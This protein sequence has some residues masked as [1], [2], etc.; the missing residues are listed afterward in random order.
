MIKVDI[1]KR[2]NA[3][4]QRFAK[5]DDV[6]VSVMIYYNYVSNDWIVNER[7]S[8]KAKTKTIHL[9][10]YK[11]Y[12]FHPEFEGNVIIDILDAPD[13]YVGNLHR[14]MMKDLKKENHLE[15][16]SISIEIIADSSDGDLEQSFVVTVHQ[17]P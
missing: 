5:Q 8:E 16:C 17:K 15:G 1:I 4:E 9:K 11:E 14:F 7:Y 6:P 3:L 10:H 2:L 13:G 12:I